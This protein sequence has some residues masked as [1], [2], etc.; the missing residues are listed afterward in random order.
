[1]PE[2]NLSFLQIRLGLPS[3]ALEL[4]LLVIA[5]LLAVAIVALARHMPPITI[6]RWFARDLRNVFLA[7]CVPFGL[8]AALLYW[9]PA[10]LARVH[11]E[12]S[13]LLGAQTFIAGRLTNVT[14]AAWRAFET[15]HV[16]MVPTYQTMYLP[17]ASLVLAMGKAVFHSF[18]AGNWIAV[19][20]LVIATYWMLRM[21]FAASWSFAGALF[22]GL[23]F[24]IFSY[25]MN[26]FWGGAVAAASAAILLGGY[27]RLRREPSTFNACLFATATALLAITRPFEGMLFAAPLYLAL[28]CRPV[29]WN[30]EHVRHVV[31]PVLVIGVSAASWLAYYNYRGTGSV[32]TLAYVVNEQE[33]HPT[34]PLL[35]E[36]QPHAAPSRFGNPQMSRLYDVLESE[37]LAQAQSLHGVLHLA[38]DKLFLLY[39][40]FIFPLGIVFAIGIFRALRAPELRIHCVLLAAVFCGSSAVIWRPEPHYFAPLTVVVIALTLAGLRWLASLTYRGERVGAAICAACAVVLLA[41]LTLQ[42]YAASLEA[43]TTPYQLTWYRSRLRIASVLSHTP[44]QHIVFVH[45]EENH[46][47]QREWVYNGP[48]FSHEQVLWAR[49]L[50]ERK[51]TETLRAYPLRRA[52]IVNADHM[53]VQLAPY[54]PVGAASR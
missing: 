26:S 4:Y 20:V 54:A 53:Y 10:P 36:Q 48:D 45:Y 38:A 40:F 11:D 7:V 32:T 2:E 14:P 42:T 1:M 8:R 13:V 47:P 31:A 22:C 23:R 50:G 30:R 12:F 29:S 28:F 18:W 39:N 16:N 21:S 3:F 51:N 25:W 33:Y 43:H 5:L 24:G 44:G 46:I 6:A 49:D 35:F 27:V 17:G 37:Q 15:F 52:W 34:R 41:N 19:A 9:I